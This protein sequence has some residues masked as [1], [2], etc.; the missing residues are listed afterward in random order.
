LRGL[1]D[2]SPARAEWPVYTERR[3]DEIG[4]FD[5][6][7][8]AT[9]KAAARVITKRQKMIIIQFQDIVPVVQHGFLLIITAS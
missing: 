5:A 7:K 9:I 3:T 8:V 1:L 2:A 6:A 4:F